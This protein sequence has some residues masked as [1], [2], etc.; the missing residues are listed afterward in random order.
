M[1]TC[2]NFTLSCAAMKVPEKRN[3]FRQVI[4]QD[5]A[6]YA[7]QRTSLLDVG[8]DVEFAAATMRDEYVELVAATVERDCGLSVR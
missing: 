7:M 4:T 2:M 1:F 3:R 5:Y 6:R 8:E